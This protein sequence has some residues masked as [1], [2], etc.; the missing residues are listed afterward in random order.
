MATTVFRRI[1]RAPPAT[2]ARR[3]GGAA[4]AHDVRPRAARSLGYQELI[5]YSFVDSQSEAD[6][7]DNADPIAVLN[8]IASQMSVMRST[9]LGGLV[10][11]LSY[12]VNRKATRARVFEIGRV[13]RRDRVATRWPLTVAGRGS[14]ASGRRLAY[15][16]TDDE[17][18]AKLPRDID[19]YDVKG[20][21]ESLLP[22]CTVRGWR[23]SRPASGPQRADRGRRSALWESS[24]SYI[25]A[26]SS[27]TN[28]R[29]RQLFSRSILK[30]CWCVRCRGTA[31]WRAKFQPVQ[32][33]ISATVDDRWTT[34]DASTPCWNCRARRAACR[35]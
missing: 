28:Y 18:W 17:Q 16:P 15:G 4:S 32:R 33:D 8:P 24:A 19:F 6:F 5:S 9:L 2:H 13:Y 31:N 29:S 7:S 27:N 22:H 1:R 10:S 21:L 23:A 35:R 30:A 3:A 25:L 20:D 14:A 11:T 34:G 12:N 26:Y